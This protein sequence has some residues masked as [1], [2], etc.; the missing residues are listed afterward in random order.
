M[1]V[2]RHLCVGTFQQGRVV[3]RAPAQRLSVNS[4][5]KLLQSDVPKATAAQQSQQSAAD[6]NAPA[7]EDDESD[8]PAEYSAD[9]VRE[10]CRVD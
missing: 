10:R 9:E 5:V 2:A 3:P 7:L 4:S 1:R 8:Q 6:N